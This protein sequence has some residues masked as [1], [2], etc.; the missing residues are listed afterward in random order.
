MTRRNNEKHTLVFSLKNPLNY[1]DSA[2]I[3]L[4]IID[5]IY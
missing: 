3:T 2:Y 4:L 5:V 1:I